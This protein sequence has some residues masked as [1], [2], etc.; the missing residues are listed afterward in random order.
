MTFKDLKN[1]VKRW[2]QGRPVLQSP[3]LH[4]LKNAPWR[5]IHSVLLR[6]SQYPHDAEKASM[7]QTADGSRTTP[8][9]WQEVLYWKTPMCSEKSC[10]AATTSV[11]LFNTL[12]ESP[13]LNLRQA[14]PMFPVATAQTMSAYV[15][16]FSIS[17]Q[18]CSCS[19]W[20]CSC[21]HRD[22]YLNHRPAVTCRLFVWKNFLNFSRKLMLTVWSGRGGHW[23]QVHTVQTS[24]GQSL[25]LINMSVLD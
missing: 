23:Y 10:W 1:H 4:R 6:T 20:G 16:I 25:M 12:V 3:F 8:W 17:A 14:P 9:L 7:N 24:P 11:P 13:T 5:T 22:I 18:G 2:Y 21:F 15:E 19:P